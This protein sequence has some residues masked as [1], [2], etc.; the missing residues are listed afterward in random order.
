M[1]YKKLSTLLTA[2][3]LAFSLVVAGCDSYNADSGM[4]T[5]EVRMAD[6]PADYDEVNVHVLRVEVNNTDDEQGWQVVSEPDKTYN[7]LELTNGAYTVLG[8]KELEAG[9]YEQIRLILASSGHSVVVDEESRNL[10]VPSGAQTGVKLNVDAEIKEDITYT[11]LL[12]FDASR[13]VVEAGNSQSGVRYL[14]KPVIQAVNQAETGNIAG[15]VDPAEAEPVIYAIADSDT[16]STTYADTV[17]GSFKLIGLEGGTYTVSFNP[18]NENYQKK[19][20]T[21]IDVTVGE[22]NDIGTVELNQ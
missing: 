12:D 16:L 18:R 2:T 5:L 8:E 4:G 6:A 21:G 10:F 3:L 20:T 9:T 22:T 1:N 15:T 19:D 17:D 11:L 13:S 7:L 14:L